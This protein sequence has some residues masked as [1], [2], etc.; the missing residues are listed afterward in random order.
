MMCTGGRKEG[1]VGSKDD[2]NCSPVFALSLHWLN[3]NL[4][5]QKLVR[6]SWSVGKGK[7][8]EGFLAIHNRQ[9]VST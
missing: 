1:L 2:W 3:N 4:S 7:V 9:T 8:V 5:S 6:K